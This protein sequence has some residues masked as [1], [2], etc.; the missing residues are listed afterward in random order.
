MIREY[1]GIGDRLWLYGTISW[2]RSN[3]V[4][5]EGIGP[6][7]RAYE[8]DCAQFDIAEGYGAGADEGLVG[9][10]KWL[11]MRKISQGC[12]RYYSNRQNIIKSKPQ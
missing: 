8:L 3:T 10:G 6:I 1:R 9:Y 7:R 11:F 5:E 2:T 12:H 4:K